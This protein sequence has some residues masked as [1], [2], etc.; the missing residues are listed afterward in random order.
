MRVFC[1][2]F[3]N[4]LQNVNRLYLRY[5]LAN[6]NVLKLLFEIYLHLFFL[7][8]TVCSYFIVTKNEYLCYY[9]MTA[10]GVMWLHL[11]HANRPGSA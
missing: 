11:C 7:L 8:S 5:L 6:V 4:F 9:I 10:I 1:C 3:Y 2:C